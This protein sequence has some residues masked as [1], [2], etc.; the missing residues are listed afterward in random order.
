VFTF[1]SLASALYGSDSKVV[2]LTADNFRN[3]VINS[4]ELWFVE[5]YA[6]WCGHCQRLVPE[7]EKL[8]Q[9]L[10]GI[11]KIGAVDMTT[12]QAAG[13]Q[14]GIRGFPTIKFFG[15]DKNKPADYE[16]QRSAQ[17][18]MN[19]A[20]DQARRAAESRLTGK[21]S[22]GSSNN[23]YNAG[24][25]GGNAGGSCGG[26]GG[27]G[28]HDSGSTG[29]STDSKDVI[30]LTESNFEELMNSEDLWLV[31]FYAPWCGHCKRLEPE[32]NQ[33]ATELKNEG[34]KVAK[35]DAT[36]EQSLAGRFGI[37]AYPQIKLF[38]SGQKSD[39]LIE[40]YQGS[41]DASSIVN[42]AIEKKAQYKPVMKS[43]QLV[44]QAIFD[45][46]CTNLRGICFIAFLPHIYDSSAN[47]R[48]DYIEV[49][50]ELAKSN[51][52][53]PVTFLWTQG[54]DYYDL[55]ESLGLGSGYPA[56]VAMSVNKMKYATLTGSFNKKNIDTF[57]KTLLSGKQPLFNL[58]E[59][60]K[61]KTVNKWDGN[62]SKPK[63][64]VEDL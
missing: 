18:M 1:I 29:G 2:K 46:Y 39:N 24:N 12:D 11:I 40:D 52:A 48:N 35:V 42:W 41:R 63:Q 27:A 37:N 54:G 16:G 61:V 14:Y 17:D 6:P 19:F 57:I 30:V 38:P 45:K 20:F 9:S 50:Q 60:P 23:N 28:G 64:Y 53:N 22:G 49:L 21:S 32:W 7:Y 34:V 4:K 3:Q 31:E 33:A 43:E 62:D 8:A 58:R 56:L 36:Q 25:A 15:A 26:P 44:D 13:Q 5:F 59:T 55:E 47:E 10:D 51:R